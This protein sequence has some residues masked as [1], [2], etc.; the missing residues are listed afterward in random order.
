MSLSPRH[1][2]KRPY[3]IFAVLWQNRLSVHNSVRGCVWALKT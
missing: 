2:A 1:L 3:E